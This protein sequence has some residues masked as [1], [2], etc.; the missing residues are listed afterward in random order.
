MKIRGNILEKNIFKQSRVFRSITLL[1]A[2][3]NV[4]YVSVVI[5]K[6]KISKPLLGQGIITEQEYSQLQ[7]LTNYTS[8]I[9]VVFIILA[10]VSIFLIFTKKHKCLLKGYFVIQLTFLIA[11][12]TINVMLAWMFDAPSGDMSLNLIGPFLILFWAFIYFIFKKTYRIL[13]KKATKV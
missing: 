3:F 6:S 1:M 9:E 10:L 8:F 7:N 13:I 12:F 11:M 4:V 5:Y 2:I